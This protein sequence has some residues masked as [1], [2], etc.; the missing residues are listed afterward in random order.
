MEITYCLGNQPTYKGKT[1]VRSTLINFDIFNPKLLLF[2]FQLIQYFYCLALIL[3]DLVAVQQA[4]TTLLA[5]RLKR[6]AHIEC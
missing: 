4:Q 3:P 1:G 5:C 2:A 6:L